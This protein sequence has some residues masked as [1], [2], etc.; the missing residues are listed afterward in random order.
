MQKIFVDLFA[1]YCISLY[2]C[3]SK[4]EQ[5]KFNQKNQTKCTKD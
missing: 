2:I 3:I 5:I 4:K 1:S